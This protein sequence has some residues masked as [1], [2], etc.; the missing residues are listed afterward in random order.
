[1]DA[2]ADAEVT[3]TEV[4]ILS[5]L[6]LFFCAAAA[7]TTAGAMV[8]TAADVT[9]QSLSFYFFFADAVQEMADASAADANITIREMLTHFPA[10]LYN[11][12]V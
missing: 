10:L 2:I 3:I 1:M 4:A 7:V 5:S 12:G 11:K 9:A 6:Y 8:T